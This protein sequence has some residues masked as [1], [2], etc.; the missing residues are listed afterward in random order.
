M[1]DPLRDRL[2]AASAGLLF[3]TESDRPFAFVLVTV[4]ALGMLA[5]FA[6]LA[7]GCTG[8]KHRSSA[9]AEEF[10]RRLRGTGLPTT[11]LHRD[12]GRE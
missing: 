4:F 10:A 8:G 6:T 7:I 5:S 9:M 3:S 2:E 11:V 1:T 12:L